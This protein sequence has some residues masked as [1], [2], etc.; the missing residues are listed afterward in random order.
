MGTLYYRRDGSEDQV[1]NN[2][3]LGGMTHSHLLTKIANSIVASD[4]L[5]ENAECP[6]WIAQGMYDS[7]YWDSGDDKGPEKLGWGVYEISDFLLF[8]DA[9]LLLDAGFLDY[10]IYYKGMFNMFRALA[11]LHRNNKVH[12]QPHGGNIG[13]RMV[14]S[15]AVINDYDTMYSVSGY[16][17]Y[18]TKVEDR[19][20]GAPYQKALAQDLALAF[21]VIYDT[22][23]EI[24]EGKVDRYIKPAIL[25]YF[26]AFLEELN[27]RGENIYPEVEFYNTIFDNYVKDSGNVRPDFQVGLTFIA[28]AIILSLFPIETKSHANWN[29]RQRLGLD[30]PS[31]IEGHVSHICTY[32]VEILARFKKKQKIRKLTR[33]QFLGL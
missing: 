5:R 22:S 26:S 8:G 21:K 15:K 25:G 24:E 30:D 6:Q 9:V 11:I 32:F 13:F 3:P 20:D 17:K 31:F 16:P 33:E 19:I 4:I 23:K 1:I 27:I 14:D 7:L 28:E 18:K 2:S 12:A 10:E 29:L